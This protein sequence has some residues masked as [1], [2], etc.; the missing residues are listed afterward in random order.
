[1]CTISYGTYC[2]ETT[3]LC[4]W[5]S[6]IYYIECIH[7]RSYVYY[8]QERFRSWQL[9]IL[10]VCQCIWYIQLVDIA[11]MQLKWVEGV[12]DGAGIESFQIGLNRQQYQPSMDGIPAAGDRSCNM[13]VILMQ[14]RIKCCSIYYFQLISHCIAT[15]IYTSHAHDHNF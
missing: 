1:M 2:F 15:Y 3:S 4:L 7:I 6:V 14:W 13:Y 11:T 10:Y 5:G 8:C 12:I 9:H